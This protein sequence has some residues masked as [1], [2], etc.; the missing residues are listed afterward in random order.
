[1][2]VLLAGA[3]AASPR[4]SRS[5]FALSLVPLG[6]GMWAGH[7]IYHLLAAWTGAG[8]SG[9]TLLGI[10]LVLLD[11]GLLVALYAGWRVA[12]RAGPFLTWAAVA[13]ALWICGVWVF[14]QP[15]PMRGMA[16]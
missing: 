2:A 16:H 7:W 8:I 9:A 15:M 13:A 1:V 10:E 14:L 11:A 12:R 5:R 3:F 6:F 4:A